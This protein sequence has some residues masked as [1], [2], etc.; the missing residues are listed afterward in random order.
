ML[1][2]LLENNMFAGDMKILSKIILNYGNKLE[3]I[4]YYVGKD[5]YSFYLNNI[6]N[7]FY[8]AYYDIFK[9]L[10][11]EKYINPH[12]QLDEIFKIATIFG[13][14]DFVNYLIREHNCDPR[15]K[16]IVAYACM[17]G[18]LNFVKYLIREHGCDVHA[19]FNYA[20]K[21]SFEYAHLD[22]II[23]LLEECECSRDTI[24]DELWYACRTGRDDISIYLMTKWGANIYKLDN[25]IRYYIFNDKFINYLSTI[26]IN[27]NKL[28]PD[29]KIKL[30]TKLDLIIK[31]NL[32][33]YLIDDLSN[34]ICTYT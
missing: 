26:Q 8:F 11:E 6:D 18:D 24:D 5:N 2:F 19:N 33:N 21:I 15:K 17:S 10:I 29:L 9:Y 25:H 16:G 7:L 14:I 28:H 22:I 30:K 13:Q 31:K 4:K 3:V 20:L 23:Y 34:I 27:S 12:C 32:D 1:K